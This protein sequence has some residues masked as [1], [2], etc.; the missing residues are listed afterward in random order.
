MREPHGRRAPAAARTSSPPEQ[1]IAERLSLAGP[2][3]K[4]WK[5]GRSRPASTFPD[6]AEILPRLGK[7]GLQLEGEELAAIGRCVLSGLKLRRHILRAAPSGGLSPIAS[8][9]PD[10]SALSRAIFPDAGSRRAPAGKADTLPGGNP[11][12]DPPQPG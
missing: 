1:E 5:A 12:T 8:G 11:G 3:G 7:E 9:I 6:I 2:F 10:L 4:C